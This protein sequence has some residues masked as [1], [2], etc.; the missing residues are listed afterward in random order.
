MIVNILGTDYTIKLVDSIDG[1]AGETDFYTKEILI[2]MQ[3]DVPPEYKTKK[4]K[5]YAKACVKTR[6]DTCFFV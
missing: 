3:D 6:V 5:R 2:S 4:F 1:R